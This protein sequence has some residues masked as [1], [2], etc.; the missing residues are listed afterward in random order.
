MI[1]RLA[2]METFVQVIEAGSFSG[3]A[4]QLQ[5][6]QP[7]ISK[8]IAKLEDRLGV[9]LLLRSTH[10]LS[11]TEAGRNFY[12]RAKRSIEEADEAELAARGAAATLTGRLRIWG[13]VS[14]G[15]LH[16]VPRLS[17]FL[18]EHPALNVDVVLDDRDV[19]LIE[20]GIDVALRMGELRDSAPD[21]PQDRP[22]ATPRSWLPFLFRGEGRAVG[23]DRPPCASGPHLRATPGRRDLGLPEGSRRNFRHRG[24]APSR[25]CCR[26]CSRWGVGWPRLCHR[27]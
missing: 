3:A 24:G 27:L 11:P 21:R 2:A 19:D 26:G 7:A 9:R 14:F 23:P 18:A 12:E 25:Q 1:D 13:A 10:G 4:K 6:G 17:A 8:T 16:V 5:V 22:V 20:A 15:R